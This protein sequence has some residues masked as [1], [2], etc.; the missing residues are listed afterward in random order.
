V[1]ALLNESE[2]VVHERT[3]KLGDHLKQWFDRTTQQ[4]SHHLNKTHNSQPLNTRIQALGES[5]ADIDAKHKADA[6]RD[7]LEIMDTVEA[8]GKK[9]GQKARQKIVAA[10]ESDFV[11]NNSSGYVQGLGAITAEIADDRVTELLDALEAYRAWQYKKRQGFIGSLITE[12]RGATDSTEEFH[13]LIRMA[14]I[15]ERERKQINES[16]K[17]DVREKFV[18]FDKTES[19]AFTRTIL[20]TDVSSLLNDYGTEGVERMLSDPQYLAQEIRARETKVA[21]LG[22][23]ADHYMSYSKLL[24]Y[25][26]ATGKARGPHM[27]LNAHNIARMYGTAQSVTDAQ[28]TRA[29]TELDPLITLYA[30]QY[31]KLDDRKVTA[32]VLRRE[33]PRGKASGALYALKLHEAMKKQALDTLFGGDKTAF[34][35]GYTREI[36][37]PHREVKIADAKE[38]AELVAQGWIQMPKKLVHDEADPDQTETFLYM[39]PHGGLQA[40]VTGSMSYTGTRR[41]GTAIHGGEWLITEQDVH[42]VNQRTNRELAGKNYLR[43]P[44]V[45]R[46]GRAVSPDLVK[47]NFMVPVYNNQGD[48][49]N[50]RYLMSETNKDELL[51]RNNRTED[52]LGSMASHMYD[53]TAT[54]DQNRG[55][56][57]ALKD[58]HDQEYQQRPDAFIKVGP[59]SDDVQARETYHLL[60]PETK[61]VIRDVWNGND[62]WVRADVIDMVFGYRKMS[63]SNLFD[64][65][66]VERNTVEAIMVDLL[67]SKWLLG[68]TAGLRLRRFEDAWQEVMKEVKDAWVIKNLTTLMG[69]IASN[70]SI[71]VWNGMN[72]RKIIETHKTAINGLLQ[73][74]EDSDELMSL[75]RELSL[76]LVPDT[77]KAEQRVMELQDA[78][79][80]NPVKGLIDEG[81]F[82]TILEDID[83]ESD[84]YSFK[85]RLAGK[86]DAATAG[87]PSAVKTTARW[88]YMAHDTPL[89][90]ILFKGTQ[91]SDFVARYSLY[92]HL[93]TRKNDPLDHE[94]A[95]QRIADAFINYD[96]PTH[97]LMQYLNDTGIVN[98]T[99]YYL[100][101]QKVLLRLFQ[102]KP[103]R[104]LAMAA[105]DNYFNGLPTVLDSGPHVANPLEVGALNYPGSLTEILPIKGLLSLW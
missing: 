29:E 39:L 49:V 34:M 77:A 62:M 28:A 52:V 95:V 75:E 8:A 54:K 17:K 51:E 16:V 63:V 105:A 78:I 84:D 102:D 99:K 80:R 53:K 14:G 83:A 73:Y 66:D 85:S 33:N 87:V 59:N 35:K 93:T 48:I 101:I 100:R 25:F 7:S 46:Q 79:D 89:Y 26:M 37:N 12:L 67:E 50:Y 56:V 68:K 90:K 11:S 27:S 92:Q 9:L 41:K 97:K 55:V 6:A 64:K 13:K 58:Q 96:V 86:L 21:R 18:S 71:L 76:G 30:L 69:N 36:Y 45:V 10:A 70:V 74:Q 88:A 43:V 81:M 20:R 3:D 103:A 98:F 91:M 44:E 40:Q 47:G 94:T 22:Q 61:Q 15:N 38:G 82:Q 57:Q 4:L 65:P 1:Y 72:P 42:R 31:T 19:E 5:L 60:P 23:H 32:D 104:G 24:G 2:A